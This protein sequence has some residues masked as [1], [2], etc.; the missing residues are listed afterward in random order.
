MRKEEEGGGRGGKRGGCTIIDDTTQRKG[1]AK[2]LH[3]VWQ[4]HGRGGSYRPNFLARG[5]QALLPLTGPDELF[6]LQTKRQST[7]G[8]QEE[9]ERDGD[10][11]RHPWLHTALALY[12]PL[13]S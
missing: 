7:Y 8:V 3:P 6:A 9:R 1:V 10:R 5:T 4:Q 12:T 13:L 11:G 2:K